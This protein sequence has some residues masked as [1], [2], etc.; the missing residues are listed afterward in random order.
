VSNCND[1]LRRIWILSDDI[2]SLNEVELE[3]FCFVV[4][5]MGFDSH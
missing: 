1:E 4:V 5:T 2:T 3:Y